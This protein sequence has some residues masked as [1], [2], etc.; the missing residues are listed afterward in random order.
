MP[1][2]KGK[3]SLKTPSSYQKEHIPKALREQCWLNNFGKTYE[4]RCYIKWCANKIS[5]FDFHVG[6]NIPESKGGKLCLENIKPICA[7]CNHSMGSQYT[8]T[9][10]IALDKNINPISCWGCFTR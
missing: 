3:N 6:H 4:H 7:R 10:W 8:I 5:V 2:K 1:L 9:E